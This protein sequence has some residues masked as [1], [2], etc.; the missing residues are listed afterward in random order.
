MTLTLATPISGTGLPPNTISYV[1]SGNARIGLVSTGQEI[2]DGTVA[3]YS[4]VA[5]PAIINATTADLDNNG[6]IDR[7]VVTFSEDISQSDLDPVNNGISSDFTLNWTNG[8]VAVQ[9]P[10]GGDDNT[11]HID[12]NESGF[13]DT[14]VIPNLILNA[15]QISDLSPSSN[16]AVNASIDVIDGAKPVAYSVVT[17]DGNG[18]GH[19]DQINIT[20]SEHVSTASIDFTVS[21]GNT[22][23][24]DVVG[25]DIASVTVNPTNVVSLNLVSSNIADTDATP[26]VSV[27]ASEIND[28]A[29][30]PNS[31]NGI[32]IIA[33]DGAAPA[34]VDVV[35]RD[36]SGVSGEID[37]ITITFS[38]P[39]DDGLSTLPGTFDVNNL[40][41]H[42]YSGELPDFNNNNDNSL[43]VRFN[44]NTGTPDTGVT[45]QVTMNQ[46]SI[47]DGV[48]NV[49]SLQLGNQVFTGAIDGA[50][51]VIY[52]TEM[53]PSNSYMRVVF[54]EDIY[55]ASNVNSPLTL[56]A[57]NNNSV[58]INGANPTSITIDN[59]TD[60]RG[61]SLQSTRNQDTI[62]FV[63]TVNPTPPQDY[64]ADGADFVSI[65]TN[66]LT[67]TDAARNPLAASVVSEQLN[68]VTTLLMVSN[69][70]W[71]QT[72]ASPLQGYI[73]FTFSEPLY[74]GIRT[75]RS[76]RIGNSVDGVIKNAEWTNG[77]CIVCDEGQVNFQ[78]DAG[79]S[80]P[81]TIGDDQD[82]DIQWVAGI[83]GSGGVND[84]GKIISLNVNDASNIS[85]YDGTSYRLLLN[86]IRGGQFRGDETYTL[87]PV[88]T[89]G[90]GIDGRTSGV[91]MLSSYSFTFTFPDRFSNDWQ[92]ATARARETGIPDGSIDEVVITFPDDI[93]DASLT[94]ALTAGD[95]SL[96]GISG[97]D[98]TQV[99]P[100]D[101]LFGDNNVVNDNVVT[102]RFDG[103]NTGITSEL[104]LVL[105][106]LRDES[107][108]LFVDTDD[109]GIVVN[110]MAGPVVLQQ[111]TQ[112][113]DSAFTGRTTG[114]RN[115]RID[116]IEITFSEDLDDASVMV[117][118]FTNIGYVVN[119]V[120]E[121][122]GVVSIG[123][124]EIST[125]F[126]TDATPSVDIGLGIRDIAGNSIYN[127]GSFTTTDK[128]GPFVMIE[129]NDAMLRNGY[130]TD[131]DYPVDLGSLNE[132][133]RGIAD[134]TASLVFVE[135]DG[136]GT[137]GIPDGA[138]NWEVNLNIPDAGIHDIEVT[139]F[140]GN[141]NR[142]S[143]ASTDE[144][145]VLS[146]LAI[147]ITELNVPVVCIGD[148]PV[149]AT[150]TLIFKERNVSNIAEQ[151]NTLMLLQLPDNFFFDT[152]SIPS[153][154][155][156]Q[157][158]DVT[159]AVS[160]IG[161]A[162]LQIEVTAGETS[163]TE[164][165]EI[166]IGGLSIFATGT[167]SGTTPEATE[168]RRISGNVAIFGASS[169][170]QVFGRMESFDPPA[171]I[172]GIDLTAPLLQSNISEFANITG[173]PLA[174]DADPLNAVTDEFLWKDFLGR[175]VHVGK[176]PSGT[177]LGN[178]DVLIFNVTPPF[179][180]GDML[181]GSSSGATGVVVS[182]DGNSVV[183]QDVRG[184]F[185]VENVFNVTN[186]T[187][188]AISTS[189][190]TTPSGYFDENSSG[191][192][193]FYLERQNP[194]T[195]CTSESPFTFNILN[196]TYDD[197]SPT[198]NFL[199]GRNFNLSSSAATI[200]FPSPDNHTI[201][202]SGTG[203]V[204][205]ATVSIN[206][207]GN[208]IS[209]IEAMF[210]PAVAGVGTHQITYS[211]TNE[212]GQTFHLQADFL[213]SLFSLYLDNQTVNVNGM[214]KAPA[215]DYCESDILTFDIDL[216]AIEQDFS[217]QYFHRLSYTAADIPN[218]NP[219]FPVG[220]NVPADID[221]IPDVYFSPDDG[222]LKPTAMGTPL[223][224]HNT[225][226]DWELDLSTV[227]T[228]TGIPTIIHFEIAEEMNFRGHEYLME[229]EIHELPMVEVILPTS[230]YCEDDTSPITIQAN[231]DEITNN[232]TNGYE[233]YKIEDQ[234]DILIVSSM[235]NLFDP[236][237]PNQNGIR[238][239]D[240]TGRYRIVY[241][242]TGQGNA[243]CKN[244]STIEINVNPTPSEPLIDVNNSMGTPWLDFND[245][246]N[247]MDSYVLEYCG[248]NNMGSITG[249]GSNVST[250]NWYADVNGLPNLNNPIAS[251]VLS[252]SAAD[253][254]DNPVTQGLEVPAVG[255][256]Q[257]IWFERVEDGCNS[258]LRKIT[259]Y[260]YDDTALPEGPDN[261]NNEEVTSTRYVYEFCD[262]YSPL[263]LNQLDG[264]LANPTPIRPN[265][266]FNIYDQSQTLIMQKPEG[267]NILQA[268][269]FGLGSGDQDVTIYVSQVWTDPNPDIW[270]INTQYSQYDIVE[271]GGI[272]YYYINTLPSSGNP[273]SDANYWQATDIQN[274]N[275][276]FTGCASDL[277]QFD[278]RVISTP[279]TPTISDF[280]QGGSNLTQS[281][282]HI[283]EGDSWPSIINQA[284]G[285]D[286]FRWYADDMTTPLV[287][288]VVPN[289]TGITES[290]LTDGQ[291]NRFDRN[292]TNV[293][294][295]YISRVAAVS[296]ETNF[297][298]CES[299]LFELNIEVHEVIGDEGDDDFPQINSPEYPNAVDVLGN[300]T[301]Q[302]DYIYPVCLSDWEPSNR[303]IV[304]SSFQ[305]SAKT[306][307]WYEALDD[308]FN[309]SSANQVI[310]TDP[311]IVT[312]GS[313]EVSFA[314]LNMT[315]LTVTGDG[316]RYF[317]VTQQVDIDMQNNFDGCE[318]LSRTLVEVRF[319]DLGELTVESQQK[320]IGSLSD[321]ARLSYCV[322]EGNDTLELF[323]G[324]TL[325]AISP[326]GVPPNIDW[327]IEPRGVP[328]DNRVY[329]QGNGYPTIEPENLY[330]IHNNINPN[331]NVAP[332]IQGNQAELNLVINYTDI[333]IGCEGTL[334]LEID[335]HPT[336]DINI[337]YDRDGDLINNEFGDFS[338]CYDDAAIELEGLFSN[339]GI[340]DYVNLHEASFS[341]PGISDSD[342][343]D[344]IAFF[345]PVAALG[346]DSY[347]DTE[348]NTIVFT[349]EDQYGCEINSFV[350]IT[351]H[352]LPEALFDVNLSQV[353]FDV[354]SDFGE[355][356]DGENPQARIRMTTDGLTEIVDYTGYSFQWFV[357]ANDYGIVIDDNQSPPIADL[358]SSFVLNFSVIVT[359]PNGCQVTITETHRKQILPDIE[360]IGLAD[361][362]EFCSENMDI[363]V[364][365]T[366]ASVVVNVADIEYW[367]ID[368]YPE[369]G[370]ISTIFEDVDGE[371]LPSTDGMSNT[372][373]L[374]LEELH[375]AA[376]GNPYADYDTDNDGTPDLRRSVGGLSTT[377]TL[378]ISY[379]DPNRMY[380][381]YQ[382][383][384]SET[385]SLSFQIHPSTDITFTIDGV[386]SDDLEYCYR[387]ATIDLVGLD[388]DLNSLTNGSGGI[389]SGNGISGNN[390][391]TADFAPSTAHDDFHGVLEGQA[392]FMS[393]SENIIQ[394]DYT[395]EF[396]CTNAVIKNI[397][398]NPSPLLYDADLVNDS[399]GMIL[400][401]RLCLG[402]TKSAHA[403]VLKSDGS[404]DPVDDYSD[405]TFIW[406][407]PNGAVNNDLVN[408]VVTITGDNSIEFEYDDGILFSI[409][410][411][412]RLDITGCSSS[413][414]E[415]KQQ[416]NPQAPSFTY[417]GITELRNFDVYFHE[418]DPL[419]DHLDNAF[420]LDSLYFVI[421]DEAGSK[422]AERSYSEVDVPNVIIP[423]GYDI[424]VQQPS[425]STSDLVAG[426]YT[427]ELFTWS[428]VG[429]EETTG[430][431]EITIL[432][433][434]D[435]GDPKLGLDY[436]ENFNTGSEGFMNYGIYAGWHIERASED[437]K[438]DDRET[439]W[440]LVGQDHKDTF[441]DYKQSFSILEGSDQL[442]DAD[443]YFVT[444]YDSVYYSGE[445]S[446]VYSPA[447][448]ISLFDNPS[449]EFDF[450][451]DF[452]STRDGVTVQV[453]DDD[454]RRWIELGD[455]DLTSGVNWYSH[456]GIS[457]AP[458]RGGRTP[459]IGQNSS[460][461]GFSDVGLFFD[462]NDNSTGE[463]AWFNARHV[464]TIGDFRNQSI[465]FRFA[466]AA[467]SGPEKINNQGKP[468]NGFAFDRFRIFEKDKVVLV[469]QFSS[470]FSEKSKRNDYYLQNGVLPESSDDVQDHNIDWIDGTL[471]VWINYFT[472]FYN[473]SNDERDY[474]DFINGRNKVD[475]GTR[476]TF[477]GVTDA[478]ETR[479]AARIV[480]YDIDINK[481]DFINGFDRI[482]LES[483]DFD[484][485]ETAFSVNTSED[486][487]I[488]GS[489]TFSSLVESDLDEFTLQP[490]EY[491]I[492]MYVAVVEKE[493]VLDDSFSEMLE[494][495]VYNVGDKLYHVLRKLLP[496]AGGKYVRTAL[497]KPT[498]STDNI[499]IIE[500]GTLL[501]LDFEWT[502]SNVYDPD[503][504]RV[505]A[506]IQYLDHPDPEKSNLVQQA[507]FLD[508]SNK[509]KVRVGVKELINNGYYV[510][511]NPSK[512]ILNIEW[513]EIPREDVRYKVTDQ[514]GREMM[515]GVYPRGTQS[516]EPIDTSDLPSGLY[517][518]Q[519]QSEKRIW[520]PSKVV[521]Q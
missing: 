233:L 237:D 502:I 397:H 1:S 406:T 464:M 350:D 253:A 86:D 480:D 154:N 289:G 145:R 225:P 27:T 209:N 258:A 450:F 518:I 11:V 440:E 100:F 393:R 3:T 319:L 509:N 2:A 507:A 125:G 367:S 58:M 369:G 37:E 347:A 384:C 92:N 341:G 373:I 396:G 447:F 476:A 270:N 340:L 428:K 311:P 469:E 240:E 385:L 105:G 498:Y 155:Y 127:P 482:S 30:S 479:V 34:I 267:D 430:P 13:P 36:N 407:L 201:D 474:A 205:T 461:V 242:S 292:E 14:G 232:I 139:A 424:T 316:S 96:N 487:V 193:T 121:S 399:D 274:S 65:G 5:T 178:L 255:D 298:G 462:P 290:D 279:S 231:I 44:E 296:D 458:G 167:A 359:D 162:I 429:C 149:G 235:N 494:G 224:T 504:L 325:A 443:G 214:I 112:D 85:N 478:P 405:Y 452:E 261:G 180:V 327:Y 90:L 142:G 456:T 72:S 484:I 271:S 46:S 472:D 134:P 493:I 304:S 87:S 54:S 370:V 188:S 119:D 161:N 183:L 425:F 241:E 197:G 437:G 414:T 297:T 192:Y 332:A 411:E 333:Q 355:I 158:T 356:C 76:P 41:T 481:K 194:I 470:V 168:L 320:N 123:L 74:E 129:D 223:N 70:S 250:F 226:T 88:G 349:Y 63:L 335:I 220:F 157:G 15:G 53:Q 18:D 378:S 182:I 435:V 176:N 445:I 78:Y 108:N 400:F 130:Y 459:E 357:N 416:G 423:D 159:F 375:V 43:T 329:P 269:D 118:Q 331:D 418:D 344:G 294:T 190:G 512:D 206:S 244:T 303:F 410:V 394:F 62:H 102:L 239:E 137:V 521:V 432:P 221:N 4:D 491:E 433:V 164:I 52:H 93:D 473:Y 312:A 179:S 382:T 503:Q 457:A 203:I 477:Y 212:A 234:G 173:T 181:E 317:I 392:E 438:S 280:S 109:L 141:G 358:A 273:V 163:V 144:I 515:S 19:I 314:M 77:D 249:V 169:N 23:D 308:N 336:P 380:Q 147:Q 153:V 171:D 126:D 84:A 69:A 415:V 82:T 38:E 514:T 330:R 115:G 156:I 495:S 8:I 97:A 408:G 345:D 254:F 248:T 152:N 245:R 422:V 318:S 448:D 106:N 172:T 146:T 513:K 275:G 426:N 174:F 128:V 79:G 252:I 301:S 371:S 48:G 453:S 229:F 490:I 10:S 486:D 485:N 326:E 300:N 446:Y 98:V 222:S 110:D 208:S 143:D 89:G 346:G 40:G 259:I 501:T 508:L 91:S 50:P 337:F 131:D 364:G 516:P 80:S 323:V 286:E 49:R 59:I 468:F 195:G 202:V 17:G 68:D 455:N 383:L 328:A 402:A 260:V 313:S 132:N 57:F 21:S 71:V 22:D 281:T 343:N 186:V 417:L 412:V 113:L 64:D 210:D 56:A 200:E 390:V 449:I 444:D 451:R 116:H 265:A 83:N 376:G 243:N 198:P 496:N 7:I 505:I 342:P 104:T 55:D 398:I 95:F 427:A 421:H 257:T 465:R 368:S 133:I 488:S 403:V 442:G 377:H 228:Q 9:T 351:V 170:G 431:R 199:N 372:G 124:V 420:G 413:V 389:F 101:N 187:A 302:A 363:V 216:T 184:T 61:R 136:D 285:I 35:T 287:D 114:R 467:T 374:S 138:G 12:L 361:G 284:V 175:I 213:V 354:E 434:I 315:P 334:T 227:M 81:I 73:E 207:P 520:K 338:M 362:E 151:A 256:R 165:D 391:N 217:G 321:M 282:I 218:P 483:P 189:N 29:A 47:S 519:L 230:S 247:G 66:G 353:R 219:P 288:G 99:V 306:F 506:F 262:T 404:G 120:S 16:T 283:C 24:F 263:T 299:N 517:I 305:T 324:G 111:I 238:T 272:F 135:I 276:I 117:N 454:G 60:A 25:Y 39:I 211:I 32:V 395:N 379:R 33:T 511:P 466:L 352:P 381:G 140:D 366:D 387:D 26:S 492:L 268:T 45:P 6:Q 309:F 499:T 148:D 360:I 409:Q 51:P 291:L 177:D 42:D 166:E 236:S 497:R 107:G 293:Y 388:T 365:L 295:F 246:E 160:Y 28:L 103:M 94:V 20:F 460:D 215:T 277:V 75:D 500:Q 122:D 251:T 339:L 475:P 441:E 278:I 401:D 196:Y 419:H 204:S 463:V 67:F 439:S 510:Y 322:D 489:V 150:Q 31:S 307:V 471:G 266:Y 348:V 264:T 310:V 191:L 185:T 386:D 436:Q